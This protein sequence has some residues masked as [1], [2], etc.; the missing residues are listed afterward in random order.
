MHRRGFLKGVFGAAALAAMPKLTPGVEKTFLPEE[1]PEE[2]SWEHSFIKAL[3]KLYPKDR[4]QELA[5]RPKWTQMMYGTSILF[6][7]NR[8]PKFIHVGETIQSV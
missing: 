7:S 4:V 2:S 6:M 3:K 1:P 8:T 5:F